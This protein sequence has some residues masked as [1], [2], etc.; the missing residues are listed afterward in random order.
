MIKIQGLQKLTLL[1]YP[2]KVACTIFTGGCNF[3]CPF[4]QNSDL[5]ACEQP[6]QLEVAEVLDFLK[7]R[8]H[9]LDGVCISGGEPLL[10]EDLFAL[11]QQIRAM[12]YLIKLDT[13]GSFPQRLQQY[14]EAELVDYVA[15]DLKNS[16]QH[17]A[18]TTGTTGFYTD[19]IHQSVAFLLQGTVPY[20]FRT[21][22]V[23]EFHQTEDFVDISQWIAGAQ[24]YFLQGF[25]NSEHVLQSGLHGYAVEEMEQFRQ[26]LLPYIPSVQLRGIE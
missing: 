11:L 22:V 1:D 26:I 12:G 17:Y 3:R 16:L 20:E 19:A 15:M 7:R 9:L 8:R 14:V 23:R 6:A 25:V 10:Q 18:E 24:Q 13:N 4:C 2:G 5:L 21:T